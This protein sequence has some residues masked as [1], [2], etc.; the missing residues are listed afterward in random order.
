MKKRSPNY[1]FLFVTLFCTFILC[2]VFSEVLQIIK[3]CLT[4]MALYILL[5][6]WEQFINRSI[7]L[8]F[9]ISW[10]IIAP[11]VYYFLYAF[12]AHFI[13]I[14]VP[15]TAGYLNNLGIFVFTFTTI[16][17]WLYGI[18]K[19]EYESYKISLSI[20]NTIFIILL[21]L[22]FLTSYNFDFSLSI[23][24][25]QFW[26]NM[27]LSPYNNN[28]LEMLLKITTLPYVISGVLCNC[29]EEYK[30]YSSKKIV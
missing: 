10:I 24:S 1:V 23:F 8:F 27:L 16:F 13:M 17:S 26:S 18:N 11:I 2:F 22:S 30:Q 19:F 29:I 12:V 25:S 4:L 6:I 3:I 21:A 15:S 5:E 7:S 9:P 20:V 28:K 14:R